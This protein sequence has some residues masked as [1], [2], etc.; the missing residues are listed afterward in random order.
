MEKHYFLLSWLPGPLAVPVHEA[1]WLLPGRP[2]YD[3]VLCCVP[4]RPECSSRWWAFWLSP[5]ADPL[6]VA[7]SPFSSAWLSLLGPTFQPHLSS[8]FLAFIS[9]LTDGVARSLIVFLFVLDNLL[10][11]GSPLMTLHPFGGWFLL[12]LSSSPSCAAPEVPFLG[13]R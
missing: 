7:P 4:L 9:F 2:G 3:P 6:F 13:R 5:A 12:P 8:P 10:L 1:L 11:V